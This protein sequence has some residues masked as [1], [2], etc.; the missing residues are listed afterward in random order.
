MVKIVMMNYELFLTKRQKTKI[1]HAFTNNMSTDIKLNKAQLSKI[2]QSKG[3]FVNG[4][5]L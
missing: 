3:F 4:I 2:I 5:V 1:R